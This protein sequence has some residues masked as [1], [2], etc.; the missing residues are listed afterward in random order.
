VGLAKTESVR[1]KQE[2]RETKDFMER[3]ENKFKERSKV[4][5]T[6]TKDKQSIRVT[7]SL[8]SSQSKEA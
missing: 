5:L 4:N 3:K 6:A 7:T 8:D 1:A 2:K